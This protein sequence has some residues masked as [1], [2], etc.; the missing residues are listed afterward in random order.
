MSGREGTAIPDLRAR[1]LRGVVWVG[2]SQVGGQITRA[3]VA[4]AVAR[5]LTPEEY[6]LA[7]LALV[8]ASLVMVFSDMALGAALVQRKTLTD[9]DRST[10][11][12]VTLGS[13][14]VFTVLGI[15]LAGPVAALYGEPSA[16]PLLRALSATFVISALGATHQSLMLREMD[17]RRLEML[18]MAGGLAGG[19]AGVVLAALDYGAWAII[20]TQV[21]GVVVTTALVWWRSPWR[22]RLAFSGASLRKLG[23]F[24]V[25][26]LGHR[27]L[28]YLQV[29]ADRF[30]IGRFLGTA[31]L[32]AYAVAYNTM[33]VPASKIGGPLQRVMS[34]AFCRI[35]DEPERIAAAWARVTRLVA[36]IS[37][38][39]LAGLVVVAPD[40]VPLVLGEQWVAA[41]PVMQ[42]LACV[43]I[44]QSLQSLSTDILMA[45]DRARFIFRFSIVQVSA[46]VLAFTLGLQW[47]VVGVAA[48]YAISTIVMEPLMP[49]FAARALGVSPLVFFR[50]LSGV[51][52]A[53]LGMCAVVLGARL[54]LVDAG[55][56]AAPRLALCIA[57]GIASYALLSLW[58]VPELRHELRGVLRRR[59]GVPQPIVPPPAPAEAVTVGR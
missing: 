7:A 21:V 56:A 20:A 44:V 53:A 17:F 1:V 28:Y 23:G 49:V 59:A 40:F 54:A 37:V 48:L 24:S 36:A 57:A 4:V 15:L 41:V 30:L 12:W 39:A 46:H 27:M 14:V 34:P 3:L 9:L 13:G 10:A 51:F 43:G 25:Y 19:V 11:F 18:P 6:G 32:G 33:L 31:A 38:P 29:N 5:L 8:F 26:M 16:E 42:I 52:Q 45:R 47:G 55:V 35:Q 2:A 22:P 58:R 50:A